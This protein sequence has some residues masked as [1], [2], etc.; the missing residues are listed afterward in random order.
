M[1]FWRS[2]DLRMNKITI[3]TKI[4]R[5]PYNYINILNG[6]TGLTRQQSKVLEA[7]FFIDGDLLSTDNRKILQEKLKMSEYNLNNYILLLRRKKII[8]ETSE[9]ITQIHPSF[10]P[11]IEDGKVKLM[12]ELIIV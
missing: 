3:P 12:F 4:N 2:W 11:K 7:L 8:I 9:G 10:I 5:L 1:S 6:I